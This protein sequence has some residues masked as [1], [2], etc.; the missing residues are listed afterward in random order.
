M[1]CALYALAVLGLPAAH[2]VV[3]LSPTF[4]PCQLQKPPSVSPLLGCPEGTLFVSQGDKR[5]HFTKVQDA[6]ESLYVMYIRNFIG[7]IHLMVISPSSA[8]PYAG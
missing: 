2:T 1:L 7:N 3:A 6:V 5:A 4:L 8:I